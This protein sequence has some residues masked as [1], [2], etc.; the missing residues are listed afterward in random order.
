M[1]FKKNEFLFIALTFLAILLLTRLSSAQ[2]IQGN[3]NIQTQSREIGDFDRIQ[4]SG[5]FDISLTQGD[6][7]SVKVEADENLLP[8]II[9][10]AKGNTLVLK[11]KKNINIEPSH[12]ITVE[13]T[14]KNLEE[15]KMNGAG[16]LKSTNALRPDHLSITVSGSGNIDLTLKSNALRL[17][18]SGST[19]AIFKGSCTYTEFIISGTANINAD[20]MISDN[21][22]IV[23]SGVGKVYVN[24]QKKLN[25]Y[26]S[27]VGK[28]WYKGNPAISKSVSGMSSVKKE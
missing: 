6:A 11:T 26:V 24:A 28:I 15:V 1:R 23:V 18:I 16:A 8:Y 20:N 25:V 12:K 22:Q 27:G 10:E 19:K 14:V 13:V 2:N 7:S 3:G 5:P 17:D 21:A 9:T 4:S